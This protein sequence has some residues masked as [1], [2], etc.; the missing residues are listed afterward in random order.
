MTSLNRIALAL[1]I[2]NQLSP[3]GFA[4]SGIITT[5]V[6]PGLPVRCA[7][8]H[9]GNVH[10]ADS[11]NIRKLRS[12]GIISTM[13]GN[14][15]SGF[16]GDG[17]PATAA[18]LNGP[19]GVAV[20]SAGNLYIP[21]SG[22]DRIRKVAGG[23]MVSMDLTLSAGAAMSSIT[24]GEGETAQAGYAVLAVDWGKAPYGTAVFSFKQNEV[25]VSEA[26]V[27]ASP[28]TTSARIFIAAAT[29]QRT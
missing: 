24:V 27:P 4:Q 6:G 26:G 23:P 3:G 19:Y 22:N 17:G 5:Y 7:D 11:S 2:V 28:P 10:V 29:G 13:A 25:T 21:D 14:E 8:G 1:L 12:D 16:T 20:D 18:Q 9:A 15:T